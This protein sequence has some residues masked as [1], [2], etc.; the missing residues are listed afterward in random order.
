MKLQ[1]AESAH[2]EK[3]LD[4]WLATKVALLE[5][6]IEKGIFTEDKWQ[7]VVDEVQQKITQLKKELLERAQVTRKELAKLVEM[8]K[9]CHFPAPALVLSLRQHANGF[10]G[11]DTG[12]EV[13]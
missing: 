3:A 1:T 12:P 2:F 6:L 4:F 5:L 8:I 13:R 10:G 7:I 9:A 11:I